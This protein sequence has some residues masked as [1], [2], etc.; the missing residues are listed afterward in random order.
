MPNTHYLSPTELI[1][2]YPEVAAN[3]NWSPREL[4][5]FLK[6]KLLDGYYDRRKRTALIKEPSF[7]Q[8]VRFVIQVIDGQKI[9]FQ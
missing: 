9:T 3:F 6:C 7:V 5:L 8:L 2:K 4:G 1:E